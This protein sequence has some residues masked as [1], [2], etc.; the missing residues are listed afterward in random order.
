MTEIRV[1]D[2]RRVVQTLGTSAGLVLGVVS[3]S[4]G[5]KSE[6]AADADM[7]DAADAA[8]VAPPPIFVSEV[9]IPPTVPP[10]TGCSYANAPN[11]PP[12]LSG[13]LDVALRNT[14]EASYL[15]GNRL[16]STGDADPSASYVDIKG[17]TVRITD[18]TGHELISYTR[19]ASVVVAP[20]SG[21]TPGYAALPGLTI[22]DQHTVQGLGSLGPGDVRSLLTFVRVFG[23]TLGGDYVEADEFELPVNVC[24]GCLIS[25]P[26][27]NVDPALP[28]PNCAGN[29]AIGSQPVTVPCTFEDLPIDCSACQFFSAACQGALAGVEAGISVDAGAPPEEGDATVTGLV[30]GSLEDGGADA[31]DDVPVVWCGDVAAVP[32][33]VQYFSLLSTC[34]QRNVDGFACQNSLLPTGDAHVDAIQQVCLENLERLTPACQN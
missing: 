26:Q 31:M 25:F 1:I 22:V 28:S 14:Y 3:C 19:L 21:K 15:I 30:D 34:L 18:A 20:A 7:A 13:V 29:P 9:L 10:G 27:Q 24:S 33:C 8:D 32:Q 11:Q 17:A 12:L 2:L 16:E 5:T 6:G 23:N 4:H